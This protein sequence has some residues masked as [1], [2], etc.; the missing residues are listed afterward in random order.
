ML[1]KCTLCAPIR[2]GKLHLSQRLMWTRT[3]LTRWLAGERAELWADLPDY[4]RPKPRKYSTKGAKI[5]RQDRCISLTG[6][7]GY[8]NA[9]KSLISPPPLGHTAEVT[10]MLADKHPT[11]ERPVDLSNFGNAS[12]SLV[13]LA[14]VDLV[15]KCIRSFH[16]LSGGG[17]SGLRPIHLKNCLATE[18]RDE[19]LERC[20]ALLNVLAKGEAPATLAPFLA[21]AS[22]T[23][24]P[25]KD[26][27]IRPVAVGEVWRRLTAKFL[28]NTYKEQARSY[29]FP[30]QIGVA[31]PLGTEIGLE[32]ARQW[33]DRN[34]NNLSALLVKIDFTNAFN[35]VDRQVFL[36]Q[37]R[38]QFPGL[39]RWAEWCYANPT[40][41]YFGS[42]IISS[43]KGVQQGDPIGPLLFALALQPLLLELNNGRSDNGLQL[44]YSYLDDLILAGEQQAVAGA[45]H[46]LKAAASQMGLEFNTSKCEVIPAAGH[47]ATIINDLFP[48]NVIFRDN[49]DF[50]LLGGP[51]GSDDFCNNHTQARVGKA[52]VLLEALG[53][54]PDPQVALTLLRHCA[55]FGKL[56]YS[57]RVV[58]HYKHKS[59]L[60]CFD[61]AVR[62]CIESFLCC[63]FSDS[64]WSL[65]GL[66]SKMGGLGLRNVELHSSAAFL[67]SQA[68]CH[69]L[70]KELD[71]SHTWN[72]SDQGSDSYA[73]LIDVNSKVNP[74]KELQLNVDSCPRQQDLSQDIDSR[75]LENIK[76]G[77]GTNV[78]FRAH[79]NLTTTGGAGSWLH[80]VPSKA[81]GTHVDPI[82]YKTMIQRWLRMP[83]YDSEFN[84]PLCDEVVDKHGDHCLTCSCG[85]D[86]TKRHNLLRNEVFY[87]CH[88]A[89]LNPE[90]ERPGLLQPRPLFG[91]AQENGAE[92]NQQELRRPADIYIPRWRRGMP[93]ALDL[94][95][96]SGLKRDMVQRSSENGSSAVTTYED[97]KRSYLATETTCQEEGF[98]FIPLICEADGGGWGPAANAV[99]S[100]LAKYKS[101]MTGEQS[102]TTASRLLQSLGLILHKENARAILRRAPTKLDRDFSE[103]LAASVACTTPEDPT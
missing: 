60:Q 80:T 84:C 95:V 83:L 65:A 56:V 72:P 50:E 1:P 77:A 71:P 67:S 43:E 17:P 2:G 79:L 29:F 69:K 103:L 92:R 27:G 75:T 94:A 47:D 62:D 51:I 48:S 33:T 41:L 46:F 89:G 82:L 57:L 76:E 68:A 11:A 101:V 64:E 42:E 39:A 21:G 70:C 97:F 30:L 36:E 54:L 13:P 10:G 87:Q 18:H 7:G 93:V 9:C 4:K 14:D 15:N 5:Q 66:S 78:H 55:S 49:G 61:N 45:F 16:R 24:L 90:L 8:S 12:G 74:G 6:E 99:W 81:L 37:C 32:T 91:S 102:S 59:A 100:E 20:C 53:E 58:P 96:T 38:H 40:N 34:K 19:V 52:V 22:L 35:C 88:S 26:D 28:C 23:A 25:K 44:V 98:N 31:Q 63:S 3:R 73:A 85:G 86:R